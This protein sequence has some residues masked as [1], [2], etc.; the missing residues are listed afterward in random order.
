MKF[1]SVT[2]FSRVSLGANVHADPRLRWV[3]LP[4]PE[5]YSSPDFYM[6]PFLCACS[7]AMRGDD[8][9][10][11]QDFPIPPVNIASAAHAIR[12]AVAAAAQGDN[13]PE[14]LRADLCG[15]KNGHA[16][17]PAVLESDFTDAVRLRFEDFY[18]ARSEEERSMAIGELHAAL[19][20]YACKLVKVPGRA[21]WPLADDSPLRQHHVQ[22]TT[23]QV[24]LVRS[25]YLQHLWFRADGVPVL[26]Q[27]VDACA[28]EEPYFATP[29]CAVFQALRLLFA[30]L[31]EDDLPFSYREALATMNPK[32]ALAEI[33]GLALESGAYHFQSHV[34]IDS[35]HFIY[36]DMGV[37]SMLLSGIQQRITAAMRKSILGESLSGLPTNTADGELFL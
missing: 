33:H 4:R 5:G 20:P 31:D 14:T 17:W 18:T 35:L 37:G 26:A 21:F 7:K 19:A 10:S 36:P 24:L 23:W 1:M 22:D 9:P 16:I 25:D 12:N 32:T 15:S 2:Q 3:R 29:D 11:L 27:A 13:P 8:L 6:S 28:V 30:V 34:N